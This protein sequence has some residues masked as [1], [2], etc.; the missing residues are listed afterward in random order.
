MYRSTP[1]LKFSS[2]EINDIA[3]DLDGAELTL[4]APG[5][6]APGSPLPTTDIAR[7]VEDRRR[8]GALATWLDGIGDRFMHALEAAQVRSNAA[9]ALATGGQIEAVRVIANLAGRSAPLAARA[10]GKLFD[11]S[12]E[13][14]EGAVGLAGLFL[15]PISAA[16]LAQ[17]FQAF[18]GLPTRVEEFSGAEVLILTPVRIGGPMR[19]MLGSK[20]HLPAAG[21]EIIVDGGC[22]PEAQEW[23][24]NLMRRRALRLLATSFIGSPSPVASLFLELA[25][26]NAPPAALDGGSALGGLAILG[27]AEQPVRFPLAD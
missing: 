6:A 24:R 20:C 8:G 13:V 14:P 12:R 25:P 19:R 21:I 4:A 18:T 10:G 1:S 3:I 27:K 26:D 15:G 5:I 7:I 16:G 2:S 11:T 22:R 9:F 23:A 17:L